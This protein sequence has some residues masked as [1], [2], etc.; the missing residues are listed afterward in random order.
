[1]SIKYFAALLLILLSVQNQAI[2]QEQEVKKDSAKL[3]KDIEKFSKKRGFTKF[4]HG[5]IFEPVKTKKAAVKRKP[6][7]PKK[8]LRSFEG[9]IIRH[10]NVETLDPFGFS[11]KD[12]ARKPKRYLEKVGNHIHL[13]SKVL[14]IKNLLLLK[15]NTPFDSLIVNESERLIRS[16][17]YVRSVTITPTVVPGT[18]DSV[19]VNIRV[20]DSWSLI[21]DLSASSSN[22]RF[23][24]TE[25]NFFGLGHQLE[26]RYLRDFDTG[27]DA[28]SARY[29][30]PNI[31]N[32][33]IR[34]S[35]A[36]EID[37]ENDYAKSL[38]IERPFFSPFT[39]WAA[40]VFIEQQ[41]RSDTLADANMDYNRQF[42]K[43]D[44]QDFWAG[45]SFRV[46]KGNIE[47]DRTTNL[48]TALR[49]LNVNYLESPLP[50]YDSIK[51]YSGEK[52]YMAGIGLSSRQFVEDKYIFNYGVVEDVPIGRV[53]GITGG[54]Q[55]KNDQG[56]LYLG[57]R[58]AL[59]KY[60]T[61]GY[62][63]N[64]LEM[65]SFF[66]N[67]VTQQTAITFQTNYFT[68]LFEAGKWKFRQFAKARAVI[69]NNRLASQG[70][71]VTLNEQS[72]IP[73][74]R[75]ATLFGS[76]KILLTLQ[77]QAYSP[78]NFAGFRLNPYVGYS[79]GI[80]GNSGSGFSAGKPYHKVGFGFII[81]NDYLVF[82]S[83]QLSV[84]FYPDLPGSGENVFRTNAFSTED[85]GFQNF[86]FG[87]PQ[88]VDYQ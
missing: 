22:A 73:G 3:Y 44:T 80:L 35:L 40:G 30:V 58:V 66:D 51:Y 32:T 27:D 63:S 38:T 84:A 2:A 9:K 76:K 52:F 45:H 83:F 86:D 60:Y 24:L 13:K 50:A 65:G 19:D 59:G 57:A 20:L 87:K 31:M 49:F 72:G 11:D 56:R 47:V 1:M 75:S 29:T 33:Y 36:Y 77:T 70:D 71:L 4:L 10:I 81:S 7:M 78:W 12:P 37:L 85:F 68:N 39:R 55:E 21:P 6:K 42:F 67:H 69:G 8:K 15:R 34:T 23:D 62:M 41:F 28:Y 82:S 53:F 79:L 26:N 54:W 48:I 16:Q 14:T 61:W 46:F 74:F 43:Y 18:K 5:L 17:R 88:T 25:R 64:N